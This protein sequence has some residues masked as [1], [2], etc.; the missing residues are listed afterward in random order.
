MRNETFYHFIIIMLLMLSNR[1]TRPTSLTI[2]KK[3]LKFARTHTFVVYK[4][5]ATYTKI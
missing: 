3:Y 2:Q 4:A 1:F 5:N